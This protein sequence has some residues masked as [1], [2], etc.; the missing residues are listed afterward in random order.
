MADRGSEEFLTDE[1]LEERDFPPPSEEPREKPYGRGERGAS[2][3]DYW[4]A[5]TY[6]AEKVGEGFGRAAEGVGRVFG[7]AGQKIG[8]GSEWL[9]SP[10]EAGKGRWPRI[11]K[12]VIGSLKYLATREGEERIP[13]ESD[14]DYKA[15]ILA[16]RR[17]RGHKPGKTRFE[18]VSRGV[19][20]AF[21]PNWT[22][23]YKRQM[24]FGR[25]SIESIPT[26]SNN[27]FAQ[28]QQ[29][30]ATGPNLAGM[31]H[32]TDLSA[33][34]AAGAPPIVQDVYQEIKANG[35]VDTRKNVVDDMVRMGYSSAEA[36][37]AVT[38]LERAGYIEKTGLRQNGSPE[39]RITIS[40][41]R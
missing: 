20:K 18:R 29:R 1:E 2:V 5:T 36:G 23:E 34:R 17:G 15:R 35:D 40:V 27:P 11:A 33:L 25:P 9:F 4:E 12:P 37:K 22:E 31:M 19:A 6:A 10:R 16:K 24:Y 26:V 14:A 30:M 21:A 38:A 28:L 7:K 41:E 8:E 39:Y 32:R 3:P 13:G